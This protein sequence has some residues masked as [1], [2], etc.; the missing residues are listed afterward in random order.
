VDLPVPRRLP[1]LTS[2]RAFE[3]AGR[4]LSFTRAAAE[5]TVTQAAISHQV[6]A[7]E[8]HL[9]VA[10]FLR[11]PRQLELT[12]AGKTLLPVVRD[13]FNRISDSA[14]S[15]S[16]DVASVALTVRLAPSFAAKWL[17]PRLDDFRRKYPTIDLSLTHS[18]EPADFKNQPIDIAIT[19]GKGDWRGVVAHPVLSIDFF[20]VCSAAFMQ[21]EHSLERSEN[22]AHYT[23]LHDTDHSA[24]SDWLALAGIENIDPLHGTVMD[25][26]NVLIQAAIDGLGVA[27]G[28][29]HFVAD[30]LASGRLVQPF[31][32]IMHSDYAYYVVCPKKHLRRT[33]VSV[34]KDWLMEQSNNP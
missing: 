29:T 3:A 21:G 26:T 2:L 17:S 10:L 27:L 1:P 15:I 4:H 34:F 9:D 18:N 22:L 16:G 14:A 33:E 24:W 31:D 13:A 30:H 25:D 32:T 12:K 23:L 5:L 6:K 20:P 19:Y 8:E 28:S 7:L 11:L